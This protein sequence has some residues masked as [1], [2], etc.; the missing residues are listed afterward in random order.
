[1]AIY[2]AAKWK[3]FSQALTNK[4]DPDSTVDW[5]MQFDTV[6]ATTTRNQ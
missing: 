6:D 2:Q 3:Q 4:N 5:L 1:M